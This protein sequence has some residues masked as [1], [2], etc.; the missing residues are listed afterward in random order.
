FVISVS[1]DSS[2]ESMG[3]STGLVIL[4]GTIPTT[5]PDTTPSVIPPSTHIDTALTPTLPDYTPTS[6]DYSH[7]SDM[8]SDPSVDPSLD[9]ISPL[10]A[11]S[12]F[13]SS[14]DD[15]S[16]SD[17]P[18]IPPLPTRGTPFTEMTLSAQSTPIVSVALRR[19]IMI[20]TPRQPIPHGRPYH[21]H[22]NRPVHM[23][24]ARKRVGPLPT[25]RL[26]VRHS[27]DHSSSDHFASDDSSRDSSSSSSSETLSDPSS[28]D[29]SDSSSNHSLPAP[30]SGSGYQQKDRKPSQNDKTE[31]GME[32]T[33]Q[34]QAQKAQS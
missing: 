27:I 18:D 2:E 26:A 23:M 16:D 3:T 32:K 5:I 6:P 25:H 21:Y 31:H 34:N 4:F 15:S 28:D 24:T 13:L 33:V 30:S 20:L 9:Y 8:E 7:A 12:P 10:L 22:L 29:L 14:T 1:S 17:T 11:I 19:R